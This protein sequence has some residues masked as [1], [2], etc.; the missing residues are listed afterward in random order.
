MA[1][2]TAFYS[3]MGQLSHDLDKLEPLKDSR[4][5]HSRRFVHP[6]ILFSPVSETVCGR[7]PQIQELDVGMVGE[8]AARRCTSFAR[9]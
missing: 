9:F 7:G 8:T 6:G 5:P 2:L 4:S 1:G 3:S